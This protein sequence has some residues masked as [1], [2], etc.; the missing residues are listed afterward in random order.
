MARYSATVRDQN[1]APIAGVS[2]TVTLRSGDVP[3]LTDDDDNVLEQ[4]LVTDE[5]GGFY[6][7]SEIEFYDFAYYYGGRLIRRDY[8][9]PVGGPVTSFDVTLEMIALR[10]E[11]EVFRDQTETAR[12]I[13]IAARDTTLGYR[14]EA[15]GFRDDAELFADNAE[16]SAVSAAA[17]LAAVEV[18]SLTSGAYPNEAAD[19]V[20]EGLTQAS[21]GAIT[22]GSGGT[23]G[24]FALAW[25][26]GNFLVDP[27]GTFTVAG[28]VLTAVTITGPGLY[29]GASPTVPTPD[30]S[31][32]TGLTGAAVALTAVALVVSGEGY[33]VQSA[34]GERLE[35]YIN[36]SGV[37][38]AE[39]GVGDIFT[40][41]VPAPEAIT[42]TRTL[43]FGDYRKTIF[44]DIPAPGP[45]AVT[46]MKIPSA[47]EDPQPLGVSFRLLLTGGAAV[48]FVSDDAGD[49]V[50]VGPPSANYGLT[51]E[52]AWAEL[53][54]ESTNVWR[55]YGQITELPS[56]PPALTTA[57]EV[58]LDASDFDTLFQDVAG[59]IPVTA[60][61]DP[62]CYVVNKGT[63]GGE[64]VAP[65]DDRGYT[66]EP[67]D[68][69]YMLVPASATSALRL[70][71]AAGMNLAELD[72]FIGMKVFTPVSGNGIV[73][74][75]SS[76]NTAVGMNDGL[77]FNMG[78][79]G[80]AFG[81]R[82]GSPAA[83]ASAAGYFGKNPHVIELHKPGNSAPFRILIDNSWETTTNESV[84]VT[85]LGTLARD[86]ILG[87]MQANNPEGIGQFGDVGFSRVVGGGAIL[88]TDQR[89]EAMLWAQAQTYGNLPNYPALTTLAQVEA[90]RDVLNDELY[91]GG[92]IPT[93]IGTISVDAS[94]R[95]PST[96][97]VAAF[98]KITMSGYTRV[99][100]VYTPNSARTD[101]FVIE[102]EG[103]ATPIGGN[104]NDALI[105][106]LMN[107]NV[108]TVAIVL[109]D[110]PNDYTSGSPSG[111]DAAMDS[112]DEWTGPVSIAYN[113]MI[114]RYPGAMCILTGISGGGMASVLCAASDD[115]IATSLSI[116]G[117]IPEYF[118]LNRD[119]EQGLPG[120]TAGFMD[121][122]LMAAA[123]GR[124][125]INRLHRL[126]AVGFGDVVLATRPDFMPVLGDM[127]TALDG[128]FIVTKE[129]V[130]PH[131]YSTADRAAVLA[132]LP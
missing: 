25:T 37:A 17:S 51:E 71:T 90:A 57:H 66:L 72:M 125:C 41:Q 92:G 4:P 103:H 94:P 131:A 89:N 108:P 76:T 39:A 60:V 112:L 126:D 110:G 6:F 91:S 15:E 99:P 84:V 40:T 21:V 100:R 26:G 124:R 32:S 27:T 123:D 7:N 8:S 93:E 82:A 105:Q 12:D 73:S 9:V 122:A 83:I 68:G 79:P 35:R 1:E 43:N 106:A 95:L 14:D 45:D 31:A 10:N 80:Y 49:V 52:N 102:I 47:S 55:L 22:A 44:L 50:I 24:T 23:D 63:L 118:H 101:V 77:Y 109:P 48:Q 86:L 78:A 128:T 28:G 64:A 88:T 119:H 20:P 18:V 2:I 3:V 98:E 34:D 53:V 130:S 104:G 87:A 61:G 111:H 115:R 33:W 113:T 114:D 75:Q 29:I 97:N 54:Q 13:T 38:T 74:F 65:A 96:T 16:A 121:L 70:S 120:I 67:I 59:T 46:T 58:I 107:V 11:A 132:E 36:D 69:T 127:A 30:F 81:L 5:Y 56:T 62:V 85:S 129:N 116:V 117:W 19:D 42:G